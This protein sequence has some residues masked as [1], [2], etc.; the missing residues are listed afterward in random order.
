MRKAIGKEFVMDRKHLGIFIFLNNI[1]DVEAMLFFVTMLKNKTKQTA[2]TTTKAIK[3]KLCTVEK[4]ETTYSIDIFYHSLPPVSEL[5]TK[6][7]TVAFL[8]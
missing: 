8:V 7:Q 2:T 4:A 5:D 3:G 6:Q 1:P